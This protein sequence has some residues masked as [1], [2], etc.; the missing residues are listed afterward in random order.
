MSVPPQNDPF[1]ILHKT[2]N[3]QDRA[4]LRNQKKEKQAENSVMIVQ[5]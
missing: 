5:S 2:R 1:F 4:A 3:L